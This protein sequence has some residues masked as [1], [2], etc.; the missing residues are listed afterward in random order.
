MKDR[1]NG[2]LPIAAMVALA[3]IIS[4][5][6]PDDLEVMAE[7]QRQMGL[8]ERSRLGILAEATES[9]KALPLVPLG[10][11]LKQR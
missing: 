4:R 6:Q 10:S 11:E 7:V 2:S 1:R 8:L 9:E 3:W 5:R